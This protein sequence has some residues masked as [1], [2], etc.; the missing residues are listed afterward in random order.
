MN[1]NDLLGFKPADFRNRD[2][3][4]EEMLSW[5][6]ACDAA[7]VHSGDSRDPHAELTSGKCSNGFFDCLRVLKYVKLSE[8]LANQLAR[9]IRSTIGD[10]NVD[11]V[12]ASPMAGITFGHDVARALGAQVF[13]F[14]EKH[15][16]DKDAMLWNRLAIPEGAS[17]LQI[18]ELTTTAK[19]L[20]AV[21]AAVNA[22]NPN[23]VNWLPFIGILVH[24]PPQL[25][26]DHYG[27]RKVITLIET[28]VWAV[29]PDKCQLCASG[30]VRYK[31]K[32]HWKQLTGKA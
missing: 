31:P 16:D 5:F 20:N 23:P 18:E 19:T 30:S 24:R 22:G 12:I 4:V 25:P 3:S 28:E 26:V 2:V 14:T 29:D 21:Q 32:T 8:I 7:W 15:P 13:M 9:K 1:L 17:V 6:D 10:Q 27:D 11:W